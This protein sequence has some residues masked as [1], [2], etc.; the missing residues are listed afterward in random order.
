MQTLQLDVNLH[1]QSAVCDLKNKKRKRVY[2]D[3]ITR[4]Q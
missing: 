4:L 1:F 3:V 2:F